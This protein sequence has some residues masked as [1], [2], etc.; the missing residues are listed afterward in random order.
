[1]SVDWDNVYADRREHDAPRV[2]QVIQSIHRRGQ[3]I[4]GDPIRLV[5]MY[6]TFDGE[7]LAES[8]PC[9]SAAQRLQNRAGGTK[10]GD[11]V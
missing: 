5:T 8:D 7:F 3:G 1:M 6:H 11:P 10:G 9:W 2:I 4:D